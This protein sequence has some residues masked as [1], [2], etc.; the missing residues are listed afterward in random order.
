MGSAA[1]ATLS[2]ANKQLTISAPGDANGEVSW[3]LSSSGVDMVPSGLDT[4]GGLVNTLNQRGVL[5]VT[6]SP[7][8]K[9][10]V[11]SEDLADVTSQDIKSTPYTLQQDKTRLMNDEI[12]WPKAWVNANLT[13]SGR[14]HSATLSWSPPSSGPTTTGYDVYRSATTGGP[15]AEIAGETRARAVRILQ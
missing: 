10:A 7:N 13:G 1:S 8:V 9:S 12:T 5:S 6:V 15:Y 11:K 2:I 14:R 3:E 4:L